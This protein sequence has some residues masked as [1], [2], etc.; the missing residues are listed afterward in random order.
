MP[1]TARSL[2]CGNFLHIIVQGIN[3]EEIFYKKEYKLEYKKILQRETKDKNIKI[4]AY[5]IMNNHVHILFYTEKIEELSKCMHKIN[6]IYAIYYNKREKRVGYVYRNRY[7]T[8]PINDER[9]LATCI[10]Y[11]HNNPVKAGIVRHKSQYEYS[12]YSEFTNELKSE[13]ITTKPIINIFGSIKN[14]KDAIND[15]D[16]N[17]SREFEIEDDT[18][19]NRVIKNYRK[20]KFDTDMIIEKLNSEYKISTR[21]IA[22]ILGVTRY[23]V[24][25]IIEK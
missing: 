10:S 1:R 24:R 14:C 25:K 20:N 9:H 16:N 6:T 22:Q 23:Y 15:I 21:K 7:Y 17:K 19:Y 13:I 8:K 18:D 5:C 11:I 4:I 3:K 2:L 12:S